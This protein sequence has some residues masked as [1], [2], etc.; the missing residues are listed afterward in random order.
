[1]TKSKKYQVT[2]SELKK[3]LVNSHKQDRLTNKASEMFYLMANGITKNFQ[4]QYRYEEDREDCIQ[5]ALLTITE[6]WKTFD[7]NS[8]KP[9]KYFYSVI[10]FSFSHYFKNVIMSKGFRLIDYDKIEI[11]K[12][13]KNGEKIKKNKKVKLYP[14][15]VSIDDNIKDCI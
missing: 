6:N 9:F 8:D 5:N 7:M 4:G 10:T 13:D 11:I 2:D 1:M 3:E 14:Q 15:T 12:F